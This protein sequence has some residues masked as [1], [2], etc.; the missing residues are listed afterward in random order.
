MVV[1]QVPE[2]D[3]VERFFSCVTRDGGKSWQVSEIE[4][5]EVLNAVDFV[6]DSNG[7][8]TYPNGRPVLLGQSR[9]AFTSLELLSTTDGGKTFRTITPPAAEQHPDR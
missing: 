8:T 9:A 1:A 5:Y 3:Y 6:D 4:G 2:S 7:W